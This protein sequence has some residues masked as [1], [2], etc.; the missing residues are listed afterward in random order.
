MK[1]PDPR[2]RTDRPER[3][4]RAERSAE[5]S[6]LLSAE[7]DGELSP[8]EAETLA[9]E[10]ARDPELRA[11]RDRL[12]ALSSALRD[13]PT[14]RA[15]PSV[16][17]RVRSEIAPAPSSFSRFSS[18]AA[19][20]LVALLG[21]VWWRLEVTRS[22]EQGGASLAKEEAAAPADGATGTREGRAD[23]EPLA[24]GVPAAP[25]A[26]PQ[27]PADPPPAAGGE[28]KRDD[29][30]ET[31]RRAA[32][33]SA[34]RA[35]EKVAADAG[36]AAGSR[37][38]A[39]REQGS[40]LERETGRAGESEIAAAPGAEATGAAGGNPRGA[41]PPAQPALGGAVG[42]GA[43]A[44]SA[45]VRA[46][47]AP[48]PAGDAENRLELSPGTIRFHSVLRQD[49]DEFGDGAPPA[50]LTIRVAVPEGIAAADLDRLAQALTQALSAAERSAELARTPPP[51]VP[52]AADPGVGGGEAA[53]PAAETD[54]AR[55]RPE[56]APAGSGDAGRATDAAP[57]ADLLPAETELAIPADRL[58]PLVHGLC[59]WRRALL[60]AA[61]EARGAAKEPSP[62]GRALEG[63]ELADE[64]FLDVTILDAPS[65]DAD[66][67]TLEAL[68]RD[69]VAPGG[70][71]GEPV[72]DERAAGAPLRV[73]IIL[74]VDRPPE[75]PR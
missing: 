26:P 61:G 46:G 4:E 10:L 56:N 22:T 65:F 2:D 45:G 27:T 35:E 15:P 38:D 32:D 42:A 50:D 72:E 13:L 19:L 51:T 34:P 63:A 57:A 1:D 67:T 43:A 69:L 24:A 17:A 48:P 30:A 62:A 14:L 66:P 49:R 54:L 55:E 58:I 7:L 53:R 3:S 6:E 11:E 5:L 70:R 9:A 25:A 29:L 41:P 73:R 47:G 68:L 71:A 31:L 21:F 20:F 40:R 16:F 59:D 37:P 44:K 52:R 64:P 33:E 12:A 36:L 8:A 23:P 74:V 18:W 28:K 60:A 75:P 39:S